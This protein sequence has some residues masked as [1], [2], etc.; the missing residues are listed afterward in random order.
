[1]TNTEYLRERLYNTAAERDSNSYHQ[2]KLNQWSDEFEQFMR[3]RLIIG[4]FRYGG[5]SKNKY[6]NIGYIRS[7]IKKYIKTGNLECLVDIANLAMVEYIVSEHPKKHFK[8][9]DDI[10]HAKTKK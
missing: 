8:A 9:E 4:F 7:K 1:M 6:D 5:I 10:T 2:I 3:N